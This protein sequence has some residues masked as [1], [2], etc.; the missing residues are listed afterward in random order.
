MQRKHVP[1][2]GPR[3]WLALSIVSIFGAN[4]GD[5]CSHDLHLGHALGLLPMAVLLGAVMVV[6]RKDNTW[7]QSYYWL[8][9]VIIRAAATNIGDLVTHDLG[10]GR[11]IAA[12]LLFVLLALTLT[13]GAD[14]SAAAAGDRAAIK[15]PN[16]LPDT[17]GFY[18]TAMLIAGALGTVAGDYTS[19]NLHLG[20][21]NAG[22]ILSA[23]LG[24]A[25]I[26]GSRGLLATTAY[27]WLTIVLVR[28]AGTA[29]GDFFAGRIVGIG[30]PMSTLL[31]GALFCATILIWKDQE[32]LLEK[33]KQPPAEREWEPT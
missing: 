31:T 23:I 11:P 26:G 5:F 6:E 7:N 30:L 33:S 19:S 21:G 25:F 29:V 17:N 12:G 24:V 1:S 18:W 2:M 22:L 32:S 27:Y 15:A 13:V 10:L 20:T 28:A 9:I 4:L 14:R 16:A 8:A 3:Y